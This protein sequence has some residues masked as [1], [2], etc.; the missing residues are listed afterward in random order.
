VFLDD[1]PS[2]RYFAPVYYYL[3]RAREGLQSPSAVEEYRNYLKIREKAA[4]DPLA[5]DAQKRLKSLEATGSAG[6]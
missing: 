3:G 1:E 2:W 4:N 6:H 5:A